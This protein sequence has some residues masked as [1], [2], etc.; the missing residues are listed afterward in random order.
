[1]NKLIVILALLF[2]L[3]GCTKVQKKISYSML[4]ENCKGEGFKFTEPNICEVGNTPSDHVITVHCINRDIPYVFIWRYDGDVSID[5]RV[6]EW[7][8]KCQVAVK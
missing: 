7:W 4:K 3:V 1:M 2:L 5:F 8:T 6:L